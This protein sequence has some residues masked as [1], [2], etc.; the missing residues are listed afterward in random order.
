M[1]H[2]SPTTS[3]R[4]APPAREITKAPSPRFCSL[5]VLAL[6]AALFMPAGAMAIYPLDGPILWQAPQGRSHPLTGRIWDVTKGRFVDETQLLGRLAEVRF[7]VTGE[8]H[9]NPD[10]HQLQLRILRAMFG[11][12]RRVSVGFEIFATDDQP[13]L[14]RYAAA[15]DSNPDD[16]IDNLGWGRRHRELWSQYRPL[17][18]FAGDSGLPLVAMGLTRRE[19][20]A[21]KRQGTEALQAQLV[22]RFALDKPLPS[23]RQELLIRDLI[24]AHCGLLFSPNLDALVL[25]QRSRDATMA[26]RL[27]SAD[28]GSG[29]L[30][31]AGYGHA[32]SDRGVP[33]LLDDLRR[34]G[35]L[36]SVLFASVKKELESPA[37][38]RSW[39]GSDRLPFDYVWFT[40][41]VDDEDPCDR[42]RRIYG[43][44][45]GTS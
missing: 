18:R 36:V 15:R 42:L 31:L 9:I 28:V 43:G 20:A 32:R 22:E 44:K 24:R 7:V 19:T 33:F 10:H 39:F 13:A 26:A 38:Y 3:D 30:L 16:L 27:M 41:R 14:D 23:V 21:I 11:N 40:P 17:V 8:S 45:K 4:I 34:R 25:A 12:G 6:S 37:A 2:Q 35:E 5:V 29:S 1:H